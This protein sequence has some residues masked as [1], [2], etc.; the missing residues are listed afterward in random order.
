MP[1]QESLRLVVGGVEPQNSELVRE[2]QNSGLEQVTELQSSVPEGC[3]R[4][5]LSAKSVKE[6]PC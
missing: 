1:E 5:E 3:S 6:V 2:L 4:R